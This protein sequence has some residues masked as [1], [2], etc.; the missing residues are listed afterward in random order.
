MIA[1]VGQ[2]GAAGKAGKG[3]NGGGVLNAGQDGT[4]MNSGNGGVGILEGTLGSNGVFGSLY[5]SS[6]IYPGDSQ[7]GDHAGSKYDPGRTI[8]CTKGVYWAQQGI[9]ACDN[10]AGTN[11][12][13]L[14]DGTPVTNTSLITRG[15]KA[16]YN[17]METAGDQDG[18]GGVGGNGAT[19]GQGASEGGGGGGSGYSDGTITVVDTQQGGSTGNARVIL[20]VVT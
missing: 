1:C 17:I 20:R 7:A 12:F 3:G 13:R 19:G 18:N 8:R 5:P 15:F 10:M 6:L 2:G 14:P 9:G 4:G 11:V 16:G